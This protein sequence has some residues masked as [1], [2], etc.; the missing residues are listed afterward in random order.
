M[1]AWL[2]FPAMIVCALLTLRAI[3]FFCEAIAEDWEGRT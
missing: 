3:G 1:M 2:E